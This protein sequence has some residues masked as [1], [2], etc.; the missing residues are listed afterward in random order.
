MDLVEYVPIRRRRVRRLEAF[1]TAELAVDVVEMRVLDT[2]LNR[3]V[4][5]ETATGPD[6]VL[7]HR[8]TLPD[9][10]YI[11]DLRTEY[12]G[13]DRLQDA[14]FPVPEP[15]L[16]CEAATVVGA[17]F[18]LATYLAGEAIP[19]GSP[20]PARFQHPDARRRIGA[21]LID[22]MAALHA[23]DG[24]RFRACRDH[25]PPP[26]NWRSRRTDS[27]LPPGQWTRSSSA[28]TGSAT[29]SANTR[30]ETPTPPCST[31]ASGRGTSASRKPTNRPSRAYSTGRRPSAAT[32]ASNS[33]TC[34]SGGVAGTTPR[35]RSTTS[36]PDSATSSR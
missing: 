33:R 19:L 16:F 4:V 7:R 11:G 21:H 23:L 3:H 17:P 29:G 24:D 28:S 12:E 32:P 9:A 15:V 5:A 14:P 20:L 1:L 35:S 22:T 18:Y 34:S 25:R 26:S 27:R 31:G 2:G 30:H 13:L 36:R 8:D 10:Y 6:Y